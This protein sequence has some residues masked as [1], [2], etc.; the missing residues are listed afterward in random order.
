MESQIMTASDKKSTYYRYWLDIEKDIHS[1]IDESYL[2]HKTIKSKKGGEF[3]MTYIAWHKLC[4][5]LDQMCP[6]WSWEIVD[7]KYNAVPGKG[8]YGVEF[9]G[10]FY[11]T[12][13]LTIVGLSPDD[14]VVSRCVMAGACEQIRTSGYGDPMTNASASALR[15]ACG[16]FG[17]ARYLW[18]KGRTS[19]RTGGEQ[20]QYA[21]K[22][23]YGFDSSWDNY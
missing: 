8:Q 16:T 6:G 17:I 11:L 19:P 4:D 7:I 5:L 15:R 14:S 22:P 9:N 2:E 1:H 10:S 20:Q 18:D 21:Q 13:R 12:G 23:D 3:S